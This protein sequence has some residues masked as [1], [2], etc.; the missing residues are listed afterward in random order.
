MR[1][2][3]HATLS[4]AGDVY[5]DSVVMFTFLLLLA[6]Y[7][8]QRLRRRLALEDDLLASLPRRVNVV[9]SNGLVETPVEAVQPGATVWVGEGERL[10]FDGSLCATLAHLDE[11]H[12]TGESAPVARRQ[13]EPVYAGSVNAGLGFA[14]RVTRPPAQDAHGDARPDGSPGSSHTSR[15]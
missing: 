15:G 3:F 9:E 14:M 12:L 8:E 1:V 13:D 5:Y 11:A 7:I 4:G 2:S 6:R 10:C